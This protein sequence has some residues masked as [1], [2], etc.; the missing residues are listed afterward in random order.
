[1]VETNKATPL[2]ETNK[3]TPRAKCMTFN[4]VEKVATA[5]YN[6]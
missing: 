2:V 3:A 1:M 6:S 4:V 5:V